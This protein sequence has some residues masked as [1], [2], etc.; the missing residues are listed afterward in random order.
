MKYHITGDC[1]GVFDRFFALPTNLYPPKQTAFI[2]LGD[3]G[4]NYYLNG[5]DDYKKNHLNSLDYLFYCVR[6]NHEE[7]PELLPH[8]LEVY[9]DE[10]QNFVCLEEEYPNIRYLKDGEIYIFNG[11]KC[12]VIGGAYS[13]DKPWRLLGHGKWFKHEQLSLLERTHILNWVEGKKVDFVLTHTC[14]YSWRPT[15]LF[16]PQVDQSTVDNTMEKFLEEVKE[17]VDWKVWLFGHYHEDRLERPYV[18]QYFLN[19]RD[20]EEIYD[21][22]VSPDFDYVRYNS[23]SP[24]YYLEE[25]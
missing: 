2:C 23:K 5:K 14:P 18:E 7:R 15:D 11:L 19:I 16:L 22:W 9:D 24:N 12:L 17:I 21:A 20:L 1:H 13:V 4:V 10:V 8:I 25:K 3:F 6:G